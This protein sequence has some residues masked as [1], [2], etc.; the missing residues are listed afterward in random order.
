MARRSDWSMTP[1]VLPAG[2]ALVL[3]A[4]N[5]GFSQGL[6]GALSDA[7]G[8]ET[9][10]LPGLEGDSGSGA[11][12]G[13]QGGGPAISTPTPGIIPVPPP[14]PDPQ[15]DSDTAGPPAAPSAPAPGQPPP[16]DQAGAPDSEEECFRKAF[17]AAQAS[18]VDQ[19]G[20][21]IGTIT[22]DEARI[23]AGCRAAADRGLSE[24]PN[25][26]PP[27]GGQA[28]AGG[29]QPAE[30]PPIVVG[31]DPDQ[32]GSG[33]ASGGGGQGGV[34]RP[35]AA[36]AAGQPNQA[37]DP[38]AYDRRVADGL[39]RLGVAP[40]ATVDGQPI[41]R[42][43]SPS[44]ARAYGLPEE[45]AIVA[46]AYQEGVPAERIMRELNLTPEQLAEHLDTYFRTAQGVTEA[47]VRARMIADYLSGAPAGAARTSG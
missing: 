33:G 46:G 5:P 25:F 31:A 16:R 30:P 44:I 10:K 15:G 7:L 12:A 8:T 45:T 40:R 3:A 38:A 13:G 9:E 39:T 22:V 41:Y 42:G 18:M 29:A 35:A 1:L 26:T 36:P 19:F 47:G 21:Q 6:G 43:F 24:P 37:V 14:V 11:G 34:A 17:A 2:L 23:R 20:R 28:R 32:A 27:A 4:S